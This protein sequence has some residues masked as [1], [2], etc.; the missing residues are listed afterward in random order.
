MT[1]RS[2]VVPMKNPVLQDHLPSAPWMDAGSWRLPGVRPLE[3]NIWLFS[4]DAF[5]GQMALRDGLIG[6]VPEDVHAMLPEAKEAALECLELVLDYCRSHGGYC[7]EGD[8]VVRPD[9]VEVPL[10]QEEPL[11][12]IGQ[13]IQEDVCILQ[14]GDQ[15]EHLL[16]GAILCFP[17]SWTLSEK[18]G[19][20]LTRIH[21]PVES[22]GVVAHRV[23]RMFD[24]VRPETPLCRQNALL[25][26]QPDLYQPRGEAD[27]TRHISG[28]GK[29]LRSERQSV[30][31]LLRTGALVFAIHTFVVEVASLPS[32][33]R[34]M[35]HRVV[36]RHDEGSE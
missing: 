25:Y 10:T 21:K 27:G 19:R 24:R 30:L 18:I 31:K 1:R 33:Q 20:P 3:E 22:Y 4:D 32:D 34:R 16:T 7:V 36:S 9:G 28:E 11:L 5:A 29:Y 6:T 8:Q 26:E 2:H 15:G 13:L 12:T 35:L 17:A 14:S 23:Q